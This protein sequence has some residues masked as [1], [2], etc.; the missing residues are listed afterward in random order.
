MDNGWIP[1]ITPARPM[2]LPSGTRVM[3]KINGLQLGPHRVELVDWAQVEQYRRV[4]EMPEVESLLQ[5]IERINIS[6]ATVR[7]VATLKLAEVLEQLATARCALHEMMSAQSKRTAAMHAAIMVGIESG[8][9][10][11]DFYA[12]L[13]TT[14]AVPA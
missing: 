10:P 6:H 2:T 12:K 14:W 13:Y 1:L 3:V 11:K 9:L 4:V 8:E 7:A 5:Q